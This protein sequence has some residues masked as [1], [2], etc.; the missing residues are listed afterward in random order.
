VATSIREQILAAI[1][2][3]V[4]GTY[5]LETPDDDRDLPVTAVL[6]EPETATAN[7]GCSEIT[8]PVVVARVEKADSRESAAMRSQCNA[9]LAALITEMGQAEALKPLVDSVFYQTGF[10]QAEA[11][12]YCLAQATFTV[13]YQTV[14]GDPFANQETTED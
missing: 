14:L 2:T 10:I 8:M 12:K 11:G 5:A 6:D 3:A 7:Y 4:S 13:Q 9:I 1:C